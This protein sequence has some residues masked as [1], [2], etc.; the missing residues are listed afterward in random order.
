MA[1]EFIS[2]A[3]QDLMAELHGPWEYKIIVLPFSGDNSL[4]EGQKWLNEEG[5]EHWQL[6]SVV[7]KMGAKPSLDCLA[8]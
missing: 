3:F 1:D 5:A 2:R 8:K 7:P 6:V 4:E